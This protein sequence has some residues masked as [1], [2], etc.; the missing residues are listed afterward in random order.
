M[1]V[2]IILIH[3]VGNMMIYVFLPMFG[4]AFVLQWY[5]NKYFKNQR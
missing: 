5:W 1:Y 2:I 3:P 4:F